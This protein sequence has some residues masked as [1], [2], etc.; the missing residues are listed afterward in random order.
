MPSHL[1]RTKTKGI[2]DF[3]QTFGVSLQ[4]EWQQ[5]LGIVIRHVVSSMPDRC[6]ACVVHVL[7]H[8]VVIKACEYDQGIPQSHTADQPKAPRGRATEL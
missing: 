5:I 1:R 8:V 2:L 7:L 4:E 3:L 6:C